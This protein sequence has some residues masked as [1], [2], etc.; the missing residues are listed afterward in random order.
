MAEGWAQ[1]LKGDVIEAYS[2]GTENHGLNPHAVKVMAKAGVDIS[3]R[4]SNTISDLETKDFDYVITVCSDADRN[5]PIFP[6]NAIKLHHGFDDPPRLAKSAQ[7]EEEALSH[8][9][10]V[11]DEIRQFVETLPDSL[12]R[13]ERRTA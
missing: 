8:Y 13:V 7:S 11:R 5:C 6:G 12:P 2:T 10:R 4:R 9:R 3:G 1:Y